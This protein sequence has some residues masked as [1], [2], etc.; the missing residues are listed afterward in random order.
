[1]SCL[2]FRPLAPIASRAIF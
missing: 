1:M 2:I